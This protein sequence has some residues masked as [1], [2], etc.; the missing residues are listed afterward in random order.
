MFV[1]SYP[2]SKNSAILI[3]QHPLLKIVSNFWAKVVTP[4]CYKWEQNAHADGMLNINL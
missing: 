4:V 3:I 1:G 2:T